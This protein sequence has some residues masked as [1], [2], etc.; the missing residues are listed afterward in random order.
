MNDDRRW[1]VL[2]ATQ[3]REL[4]AAAVL[5]EHGINT[6]VAQR[7][8]RKKRDGKETMQLENFMPNILFAQLTPRDFEAIFRNDDDSSLAHQLSYVSYC[9]NTSYRNAE[10]KA[11]PLVIPDTEMRSFIIATSTHD[12][13][14]LTMPQNHDSQ[15]DGNEVLVTKGKYKGLCGRMMTNAAGHHRLLVS[16]TN[17]ITIRMPR[18]RAVYL[19]ETNAFHT[20]DKGQTDDTARLRIVGGMAVV[21]MDSSCLSKAFRLLHDR[22]TTSVKV[23]DPVTARTVQMDILEAMYHLAGCDGNLVIQTFK[24]ECD[25][26]YDTLFRNAAFSRSQFAGVIQPE[27]IANRLQFLRYLPLP[28]GR[29]FCKSIGSTR[30]LNTLRTW[31]DRLVTQQGGYLSDQPLAVNFLLQRYILQTGF[32][33]VAQGNKHKALAY[34]NSVS[35]GF[36]DCYLRL[37]NTPSPDIH[38]LV[39]CYHT[40]RELKRDIPSNEDRYREFMRIV[41]KTQSTLDPSSLDWLCLEELRLDYTMTSQNA[42]GHKLLCKDVL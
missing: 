39:C 40:L 37:L 38:T 7:Y 28:G 34:R 2:R 27:T 11:Q 6:Y 19:Q 31:A 23:D 32:E 35:S 18:I 5:E 12:E 8:K 3:N 30:W 14:I 29:A 22:F 41:T 36:F 1:Y 17:L 42:H 26:L 13:D 15:N 20:A 9:Y 25:R 16:L 24:Q 33:N 10:D 21:R 4:K